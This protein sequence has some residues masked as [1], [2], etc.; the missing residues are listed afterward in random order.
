MANVDEHAWMNMPLGQ[1][2]QASN[3]F[4]RSDD[5]QGDAWGPPELSPT[6]RAALAVLPMARLPFGHCFDTEG[7][8]DAFKG[9]VWRSLF[10]LSLHQVDAVAY[11]ALMG[12]EDTL[13]LWCLQAPDTMDEWLPAGA[14]LQGVLTLLGPAV[15]HAAACVQALHDMGRHGFGRQRLK[16]SMRLLPD[17]T[18]ALRTHLASAPGDRLD[19]AVTAL[20]VHGAA[21]QELQAVGHQQLKLE[22]HFVSPMALKFDGDLVRAVPSLSMLVQALA[23]RL[24]QV[25]PQRAGGLFQEGERG[26]WLDLAAQCPTV[27]HHM[28]G[29]VTSRWSS[30][31]RRAMPLEGVMGTAVYGGPAHCLA[32][33]LTLA[34]WLQLGKKTTFGQGVVRLRLTP[35]GVDAG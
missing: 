2:M 33:L 35:D 21:Q 13:R 19:S 3:M 10:G 4:T 6:L 32:P 34:Q 24:V 17:G 14:E 16:A 11:A 1:Q 20:D 29:L 22:V 9:S 18:S 30:S 26:A 12:G 28:G 31:Q 7:R 23:R 5:F 8:L 27:A 25:V 15:D